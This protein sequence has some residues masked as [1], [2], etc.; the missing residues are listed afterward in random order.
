MKVLDDVEA[1]EQVAEQE[2]SSAQ[3]T[4]KELS[5]IRSKSCPPQKR[6]STKTSDERRMRKSSLKTLRPRRSSLLSAV[7]HSW[8]QRRAGC[9]RK[10]LACLR[11]ISSSC[12]GRLGTRA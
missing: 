5:K 9:T 7:M 4:I 12:S 11:S 10:I 1:E 2:L 3:D 8:M 6:S